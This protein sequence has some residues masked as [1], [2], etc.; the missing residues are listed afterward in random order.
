MNEWGKLIKSLS[1]TWKINLVLI[2]F[3]T[4][5]SCFFW[6]NEVSLAPFHE[7]NQR[8]IE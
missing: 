7:G 1:T 5:G 4:L 6:Y 2:A 3:V 8:T